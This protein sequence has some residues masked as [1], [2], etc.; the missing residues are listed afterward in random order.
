MSTV[1]SPTRTEAIDVQADELRSAMYG[2]REFMAAIRRAYDDG[3]RGQGTPVE[4][5][6]RKR[7]ID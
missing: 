7:G 1:T 6:F 4:E 3:L 5:Y 2:D